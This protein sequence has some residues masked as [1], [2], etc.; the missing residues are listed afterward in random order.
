MNK[1]M[2]IAL[3]VVAVVAVA[4]IGYRMWKK[5]KDKKAI[6]DVKKQ[7]TALDLLKKPAKPVT[8]QVNDSAS[9]AM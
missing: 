8:A 6:A 9:I 2:K 3:G 1:N 4:G 5:A 7:P